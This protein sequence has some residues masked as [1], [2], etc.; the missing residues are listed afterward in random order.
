MSLRRLLGG[1]NDSQLGKYFLVLH[2]WL[3]LLEDGFG[4]FL[5]FES[6][7]MAPWFT[8]GYGLIINCQFAGKNT[9]R[10]NT[11]YLSKRD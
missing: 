7:V 10:A 4:K 1:V 5:H 6:K 11:P 3:S 9:G 2:Q 8:G